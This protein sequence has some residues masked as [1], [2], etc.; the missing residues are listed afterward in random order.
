MSRH[1]TNH[2]VNVSGSSQGFLLFNV[3]MHRV[4]EGILHLYEIL[5]EAV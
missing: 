3:L 1:K 5:L 2:S 4:F